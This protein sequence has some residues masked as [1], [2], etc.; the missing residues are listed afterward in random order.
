MRTT[1]GS[2]RGT[3]VGAAALLGALVVAAPALAADVRSDKRVEPV[4]RFADPQIAESSGLVDLGDR[5]ATVNDSGDGPVV[6]VVE[7]ASGSTVGRTT[8]STDAVVDVEALAAGPRGSVWVGDIGDNRSARASIVV[9]RLPSLGDGEIS[10]AAQRYELRYADGARDAETLLVHPRTGRVYVVSKGLFGGRVYAAPPRLSADR[11]NVLRPVGRT[12]G[13]VTDGVFTADGRTVLLRT[14][15]KLTVYHPGR[16]G[17][18]AQMDLP[19]Q[20]QGEAL[21]RTEDR[22]RVLV[23]TEGAGTRVLSVRLA[24][25][26]RRAV[27]PPVPADVAEPGAGVVAPAPS[28]EAADPSSP[29]PPDEG[30]IPAV[31]SVVALAASTLA[32]ALG[33]RAALRWREVRGSRRRTRLSR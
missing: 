3:A 6:Y 26:L 15:A 24:A 25:G 31:V 11:V 16:W 17:S 33:V 22:D 7:K 14:Y 2:A 18:G 27:S 12:G 21:A 28:G 9:Y 4:L 8:Y 32:V 30:G 23:S 19:D 20:P 10:V 1:S 13:L 5:V 29:E